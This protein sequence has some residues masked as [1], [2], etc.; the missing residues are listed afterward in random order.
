MREELE[1]RDK[2]LRTE[3]KEREKVF[4]NEQLKRD[5]DLLKML[6][7]MEKNLL[8]KADAFGYLYKEHKKDIRATI[9]RR[10]EE[11]EASLNYRE[12]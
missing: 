4:V 12:K 5:Q 1:N 3:L 10:D 8:Q 9:Q 7:E 6:E 11:M 2:A